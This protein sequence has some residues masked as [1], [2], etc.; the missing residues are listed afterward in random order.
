MDCRATS[1]VEDD[2]GTA[3]V[4]NVYED[5]GCGGTISEGAWNEVSEMESSVRFEVMSRLRVGVE[6]SITE[7]CDWKIF[8]GTMK[9]H[10]I[11]RNVW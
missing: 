8:F 2:F 5:A 9:P 3:R 7:V 4:S 6:A 10:H 1:T 11:F